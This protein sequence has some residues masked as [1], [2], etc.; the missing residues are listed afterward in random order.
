MIC[1]KCKKPINSVDGRTK[2]GIGWRHAHCSVMDQ[3]GEIAETKSNQVQHEMERL[4]EEIS[5]VGGSLNALRARIEGILDTKPT[6]VPS[7]VEK[8][9]EVPS[10]V[11]LADEIRTARVKISC[12]NDDVMDMV[13]TCEL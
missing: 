4:H 3:N 11:Q 12:L 13:N 10:L 5:Q 6:C 7:N 8:K 1:F 2:E 9:C